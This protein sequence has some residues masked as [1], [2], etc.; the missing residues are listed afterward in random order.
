MSAWFARAAMSLSFLAVALLSAG[1]ARAIDFG[2]NPGGGPVDGNRRDDLKRIRP[3]DERSD[4]QATFGRKETLLDKKIAEQESRSEHRAILGLGLVLQDSFRSSRESALGETSPRVLTPL[5][6]A[7]GDWHLGGR[8]YLGGTL[9]WPLMEKP[10]QDKGSSTRYWPFLGHVAR[11]FGSWEARAGL[12]MIFYRIQGKGGTAEVSNG[13]GSL[14]FGL[15][16][17]TVSSR[18][19]FLSL[20]VG[21][22]VGRA[23]GALEIYLSS[24]FG[25]RRTADLVLSGGWNFL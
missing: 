10:T 23:V 5:L 1:Q 9:A 22:V 7:R 6:T 24:P 15:P 21:K 4:I 2:P 13:S 3:V 17:R 25:G 20:G 12:G 16:G 8:W 11:G 18:V 14:T 19:A